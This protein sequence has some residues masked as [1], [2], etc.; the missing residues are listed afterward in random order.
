[1]GE[2]VSDKLVR[3]AKQPDHVGRIKVQIVVVEG[4]PRLEEARWRSGK[5]M[6]F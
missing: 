4:T 3:T 1:M 6:A 5:E 2:A